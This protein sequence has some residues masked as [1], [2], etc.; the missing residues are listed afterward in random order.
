V[1]WRP[2]NIEPCKVV[3]RLLGLGFIVHIDEPKPSGP[4]G[5][6]IRG[7]G[8]AGH[9]AVATEEFFEIKFKG[10]KRNISNKN[11]HRSASS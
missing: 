2:P 4:T 8:S 10:T 9:L 11:P 6:P 5:G 3:D 1:S 7:N